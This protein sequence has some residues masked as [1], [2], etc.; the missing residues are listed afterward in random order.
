MRG[1]P[2]TDYNRLIS[3]LSS[4][5]PVEQW[6]PDNVP[7]SLGPYWRIPSKADA[8]AV[9]DVMTY[10]SWNYSKTNYDAQVKKGADYTFLAEYFR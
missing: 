5:L 10:Q 1:R 6:R 7:A 4:F 3:L 8:D 9:R 2:A